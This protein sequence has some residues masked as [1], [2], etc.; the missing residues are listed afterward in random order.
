MN[1]KDIKTLREVALESNIPITTLTDR[2]KSREL[3]EGIDYKKLG[4]RQP[5][6]LSP[7]G[8]KKIL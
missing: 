3:I 2:I 4:I 7:E 5:T 1:L 6:I 8:I